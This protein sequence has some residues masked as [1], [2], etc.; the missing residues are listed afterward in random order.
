MRARIFVPFAFGRILVGLSLPSRVEL[1]R[2]G[3][4][5]GT[6]EPR[7]IGAPV[8]QSVQTP[9][10]CTRSG[11]RQPA[12]KPNP[13]KAQRLW[14]SSAA[15]KSLSPKRLFGGRGNARRVR[16]RRVTAAALAVKT[17]CSVEYPAGW[18]RDVAAKVTWGPLNALAPSCTLA[19]TSWDRS[20]E[21]PAA[22]FH[23]EPFRIE[24]R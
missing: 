19:R 13:G 1:R 17:A 24:H 21:K 6:E 11:R 14:A 22:C 10:W 23:W 3:N 15:V 9:C 8:S 5:K 2:K 20:P 7:G 4:R 12:P 18:I 16:G